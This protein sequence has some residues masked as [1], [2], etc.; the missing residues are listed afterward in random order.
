MH[1]PDDVER[2]AAEI[3]FVAG[4]EGMVSVF[5]RPNPRSTALYGIG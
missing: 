4:L 1:E 2:V 5:M 3:R